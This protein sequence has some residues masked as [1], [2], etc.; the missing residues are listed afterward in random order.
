LTGQCDLRRFHDNGGY[1]PLKR[2]LRKSPVFTAIAILTLA[3]GIGAN[4]SIFTLINALMLRTLPV[5]DPGRNRA[6]RREEVLW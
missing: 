5:Q 2:V 4:A 3:L 6:S 1:Q